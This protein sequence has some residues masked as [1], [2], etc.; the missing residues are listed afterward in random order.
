MRI[1]SRG[2]RFAVYGAAGIASEVAFTAAKAFARDRD[3]RAHGRSSPW[4]FPIYGLLQ[5]LFEPAHDAMRDRVPA[6]LRAVA[7]AAGF[8]LVEYATGRGLRALVGAAPWDYS[9]ARWNLD[10]LVRL[11]YAPVWAAA[12]LAAERLH[13]GL[14]GRT[15]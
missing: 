15:D 11:D 1:E 4:M 3:P 9:H 14:V 10:G 8:L 13:D 6:P 7:Y 5:P 2:A 12:G